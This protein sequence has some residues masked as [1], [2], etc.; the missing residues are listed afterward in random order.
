MIDSLGQG[1]LFAHSIHAYIPLG[2]LIPAT[3]RLEPLDLG[4]QS[5][6]SSD[7]GT[8]FGDPAFQKTE[9]PHNILINS[10]D[11]QCDVRRLFLRTASNGLTAPAAAGRSRL[12][13]RRGWPDVRRRRVSGHAG[14]ARTREPLRGRMRSSSALGCRFR[15]PTSTGP[16][17]G[18]PRSSEDRCGARAQVGGP[19]SA[20]GKKG[21]SERSKSG[22]DVCQK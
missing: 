21:L 10:V 5:S 4:N 19:L 11:L 8:W 6:R 20:L 18:R 12:L 13:G 1:C 15:C 22:G 3:N 7:G 2:I 16:L 9:S 17:R 14:R